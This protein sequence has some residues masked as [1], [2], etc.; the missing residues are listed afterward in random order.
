MIERGITST[1]DDQ[2]NRNKAHE[3]DRQVTTKTTANSTT[4]QHRKSATRWRFFFRNSLCIYIG[5]KVMN[6]HL[7]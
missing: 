7:P 1:N 2:E 4:D 3:L 6:N 5:K